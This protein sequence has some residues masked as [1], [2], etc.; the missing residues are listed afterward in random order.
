M[1]RSKP[2]LR[3]EALSGAPDPFREDTALPCEAASSCISPM[4][5]RLPTLNAPFL[6]HDPQLGDASAA[7]AAQQQWS[8]AIDQ[9]KS[10]MAVDRA[11]PVLQRLK[12]LLGD[13]QLPAECSS[14]LWAEVREKQLLAPSL[15]V[16]ALM[17]VLNSMKPRS[18][19]DSGAGDTQTELSSN[20]SAAV[21]REAMLYLT[22]TERGSISA[23]SR[24]WLTLA[25]HDMLWRDA[26]LSRFSKHGQTDEV[27]DADSPG[28]QSPM[29][30]Q[31]YAQRLVH[32]HVG[33][34]VEVAWR[35]SFRLESLEIYSG[36]SWQISKTCALC[37]FS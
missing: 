11:L 2:Q 8:E 3:L 7:N 19:E 30:K 33:D 35:G 31:Q 23:V 29:F 36:K 1:G 34:K 24:D 28:E 5:G 22:L 21:L 17:D 25:E 32:P 9:W 13:P 6:R 37:I 20:L 10:I 15:F 12:E 14:A 18:P 16:P 26:Y 4:Q 27:R